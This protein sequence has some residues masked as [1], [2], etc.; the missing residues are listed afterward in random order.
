M[1]ECTPH[2]GLLYRVCKPRKEFYIDQTPSYIS[3]PGMDR[4]GGDVHN[5]SIC[6]Q[7]CG[8]HSQT[9]VGY[10]GALI[11]ILFF[12]SNFLPVK[13]FDTGDGLFYQWV[14]CIGIW[15][16]GL[17]VNVIRLQPPFFLPVFYGGILWTTG[18]SHHCCIWL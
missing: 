15:I 13:K 2:H 18:E 5:S 4:Q 9:V 8:N 16:V 17:V 14:M 12:G 11:A 10:I 3:F 6:G 7:T 1:C